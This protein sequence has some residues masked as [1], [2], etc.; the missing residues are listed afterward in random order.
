MNECTNEI[1]KIQYLY[2]RCI[3]GRG[4]CVLE[5]VILRQL[6]FKLYVKVYDTQHHPHVET[7]KKLTVTQVQ[8]GSRRDIKKVGN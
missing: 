1:N 7:K 3:E 5:M 4:N 2:C 8:Y 6:K